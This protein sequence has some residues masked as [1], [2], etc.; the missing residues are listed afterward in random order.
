VSEGKLS[1]LVCYAH[2]GWAFQMLRRSLC[3]I[4]LP[5]ALVA[6][7]SA[8][9]VDTTLTLACQGTKTWRWELENHPPLER[10]ERISMG[11]IVN[12]TARTVTGLD[13]S[14]LTIQSENEVTIGFGRVWSTN[15]GSVTVSGTIDRLTGDMAATAT[16]ITTSTSIWNYSLK[17]RPAQRTF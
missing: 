3:T 17:C 12:L 14:T 8:Q 1:P 11:I 4:G 13:R 9:A 2:A 15:A 7:S 16:A 5:V 6:L 10:T